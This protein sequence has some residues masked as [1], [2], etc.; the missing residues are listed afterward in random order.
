MA[1]G[2]E[3]EAG[4][5]GASAADLRKLLQQWAGLGQVVESISGELELQPLLTQS[6]RAACD[7]LEAD[8]GL[9]GLVAEGQQVIRIEAACGTPLAP[10]GLELE[11]GTGLAGQVLLSG[12]PLFPG[13]SDDPDQPLLPELA[14]YAM[15]GAPLRWRGPAMGFFW[16]G[17]APPRQFC[18]QDVEILALFARHAAIAIDNARL[19]QAEQRRANHI[20]IINRVGRLVSSSH[21]LGHLLQTAVEAIVAYLHHPH[22]AIFLA[23][24]AKP[25]T[26][27]LSARS[28]IFTALEM[29]PYQQTIN[30]GIIGTVARTRR[31]RLVNNVRR[32]PHDLQLPGADN[33]YAELAVPIVVGDRLLGV[34]NVESEQSISEADAEGYETIADQLGVAIDNARLFAEIRSA[35]EQARLLYESSQRINLLYERGQQI[36]VLQERQRLAR[37]LHDSVTQ[38]IF[39]VTLIAQS[40]SP[41]W[42]RD[43]AEGERRIGRLLELSQMALV[44]MRALLAELRPSEPVQPV[45]PAERIHSLS[46]PP[47]PG[48]RRLQQE[49]LVSV[50]G[51]HLIDITREGLVVDF[52]PEGYIAQDTAQEEALYRITQE[53][54]NNVLKHAQARRVR[55]RL[56]TDGHANSLIITDDGI[57]FPAR[58]AEAGA[59]PPGGTQGGFGL[60]SMRERAAALGGEARVTALPAGGTMVAVTIPRKDRVT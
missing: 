36:A 14:D 19:Y 32:A 53:A 8:M 58:T 55:V 38:L 1:S 28:G 45:A 17:A 12:R 5:T 47:V 6:V 42:R 11:P 35:L 27:V 15:I 31:R 37:E 30:Q 23:D 48:I 43:P 25:D 39:S 21:H 20:A 4:L 34:L 10:L 16:V 9:I 29:S 51:Q 54:L 49:G 26:L 2:E 40:I 60:G 13:R 59:R 7:L 57:G 50:L 44:E 33:I 24:P 46:G 41:A 18:P 3:T 52:D 22:I 56:A